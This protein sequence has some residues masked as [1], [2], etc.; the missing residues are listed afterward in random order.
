MLEALNK[1][2]GA[3]PQALAQNLFMLILTIFN[4]E[5]APLWTGRT[6]IPPLYILMT[7][8]LTSPKNMQFQ[9]TSPTSPP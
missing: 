1:Y 2:N 8:S 6:G 3:L 7:G 9:N 4:H 5:T